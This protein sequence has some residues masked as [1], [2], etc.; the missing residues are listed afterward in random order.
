MTRYAAIVLALALTG[1]GNMGEGVCRP[2]GTADCPP[3]GP[4]VLNTYRTPPATVVPTNSTLICR[5]HGE[6]VMCF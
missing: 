5:R 4:L 2:H 6:T 1:C 3:P